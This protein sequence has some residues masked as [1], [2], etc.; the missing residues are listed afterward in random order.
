M[1][2]MEPSLVLEFWGLEHLLSEADVQ[3]TQLHQMVLVGLLEEQRKVGG[4]DMSRIRIRYRSLNILD[5]L[6]SFVVEFSD[7]PHDIACQVFKQKFSLFEIL[8]NDL[9]PD[10]TRDNL[11]VPVLKALAIDKR[12]RL[13]E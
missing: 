10:G 5:L 4:L 11:A 13:E 7:I 3:E 6:I 2:E 12:A 9:H 1:Q 8:V